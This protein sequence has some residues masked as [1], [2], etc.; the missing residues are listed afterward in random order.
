MKAAI[1]KYYWRIQEENEVMYLSSGSTALKVFQINSSDFIRNTNNKL[2]KKAA[3][4][5]ASQRN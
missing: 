3:S 2:K 4:A 5:V 1:Q